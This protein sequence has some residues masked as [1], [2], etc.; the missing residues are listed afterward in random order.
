MSNTITSN[1]NNYWPPNFEYIQPLFFTGDN[2]FLY[3]SSST[4]T[5]NT[6]YQLDLAASQPTTPI[7]FYTAPDGVPTALLAFDNYLYVADPSYGIIQIE[8]DNSGNVVTDWCNHLVDKTIT[9]LANDLN[10]IYAANFTDNTIDK[11]DLTGSIVAS[12]SGMHIL[13]QMV[14]NNGFLYVANNGNST[15]VKINLSSFT[16]SDTWSYSSNSSIPYPFGLAI[17]SSYMY[18]TNFSASDGGYTTANSSTVTQINLSNGQ[19]LNSNWA[20]GLSCPGSLLAYK[21]NG[22]N[23]AYLY[24]GNQI[25]YLNESILTNKLSWT[26]KFA[27]SDSPIPPGP[28]PEPGPGPGPGPPISNICFPAKTPITTDQGNIPI[29]HIDPDIHTIRNKKIV[30]ITKT[31]SLDD[32][33]ICIEKDAIDFNYPNKTTFI[34]KD[35]KIFYEGQMI[36]AEEFEEE[37]EDVHKVEYTGEVLYNV[38]MEE[39][40]N[41]RVNNLICETLHPKNIIA[42]LYSKH[43]DEEYKNKFI[44]LLNSFF[45]KSNRTMSEDDISDQ[46]EQ[47]DEANYI[48]LVKYLNKE[49]TKIINDK[50]HTQAIC[51]DLRKEAVQIKKMKKSDLKLILQT[52]MD[53][54]KVMAKLAKRKKETAIVV[55][56]PKIEIREKWSNTKITA[57]I[58]NG[59]TKPGMYSESELLKKKQFLESEKQKDKRFDEILKQYKKAISRSRTQKKNGLDFGSEKHSS[60]GITY[61]QRNIE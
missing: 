54:S 4:P 12:I 26:S 30:A 1:N 18:V 56:T 39:H 36:R 3:L 37:F 58:E 51:V 19:I 40:D 20:T 29:D 21:T 23:Q 31:I 50:T 41:M 38:L 45:T 43:L 2:D 59:T 17:Y 32:Y 48:K 44:T 14:V 6:I 13:A 7:P 42:K 47:L 49:I 60:K 16:T 34:S 22:S 57:K 35:H 8:I 27:L 52:K 10:F 55:P 24:V 9:S 53:N 28:G 15:I 46:I 11:I 25:V 33:L 5:D 61:K